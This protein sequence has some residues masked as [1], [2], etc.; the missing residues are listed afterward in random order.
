[1]L[2]TFNTQLFVQCSCRVSRTAALWDFFQ[3]FFTLNVRRQTRFWKNFLSSAA[4]TGRYWRCRGSIKVP[5]FL[6]SRLGWW[7]K[8]RWGPMWL[9][10]T[11]GIPSVLWFRCT[12][13]G[14]TFLNDGGLSWIASGLRRKR[15]QQVDSDLCACGEPQRTSYIVNSHP[16][17]KLVGVLSKQPFADDD[18]VA[19]AWLTNY[20]GP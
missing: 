16:L 5:V 11:I 18:A 17:T 19:V 2:T 3:Q 20:G 13:V 4:Q 8:T 6:S 9:F 1:M 7:M 10:C 12:T 14:L 15:W